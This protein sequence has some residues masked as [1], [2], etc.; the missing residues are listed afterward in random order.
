MT[1]LERNLP[2]SRTCSSKTG[3]VF[4]PAWT[5]GTSA[6]FPFGGT[7]RHGSVVVPSSLMRVRKSGTYTTETHRSAFLIASSDLA[8]KCDLY[9]L[10]FGESVDPRLRRTSLDRLR[11]LIGHGGDPDIAVGFAVDD[12]GRPILVADRGG[13]RLEANIGIDADEV[14]VYGRGVGRSFD[15]IREGMDWMTRQPQLG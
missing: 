3:Q 13:L 5:S 12:L 1:T 14:R 11:E 6:S 2:L 9:E 10:E 15:S 4:K 7:S 8:R